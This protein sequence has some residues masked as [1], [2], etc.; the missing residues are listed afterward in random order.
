MIKRLEGDESAIILDDDLVHAK[1]TYVDIKVLQKATEG[2]HKEATAFTIDIKELV[3]ALSEY[4]MQLDGYPDEEVEKKAESM[5]DQN[6]RIQADV[7][8]HSSEADMYPP[9][10]D[11]NNL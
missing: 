10:F 2:E 8:R 4:Q 7:L 6:A 9:G 11:P 5:Q 3:N 1:G